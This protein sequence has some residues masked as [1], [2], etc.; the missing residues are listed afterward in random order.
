MCGIFGI[1][2]HPSAAA[3][4]DR[5]GMRHRHVIDDIDVN[6]RLR[7]IA[8]RI[9]HFVGEGILVQLGLR[10]VVD[11]GLRIKRFGQRVGISTVRV[12]LRRYRR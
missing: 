8:V 1:S 4:I 7:R 10:T 12:D 11:I 2:G 6:H 3:Q 5:I 9:R